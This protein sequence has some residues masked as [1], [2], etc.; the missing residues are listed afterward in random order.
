[1]Q[2]SEETLE[3]PDWALAVLSLL[4]IVAMLPV[5]LGFVHATLRSRAA[6]GAGGGGGDRPVGF[7]AVSTD[8]DDNKCETPMTDVTDVTDVEQTPM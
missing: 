7:Q 3:Y 8:D 4:I 5:P 6:R 1:V 2:A